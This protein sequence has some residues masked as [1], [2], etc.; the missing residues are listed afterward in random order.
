M[1][2]AILNSEKIIT[3]AKAMGI[4][5]IEKQVTPF[6]FNCVEDTLNEELFYL[7][8]S[9]EID[10]ASEKRKIVYTHD[11][12]TR[13]VVE[14]PLIITVYN[15]HSQVSIGKHFV[16]HSKKRK[17]RAFMHHGLDTPNFVTEL[18]KH[19]E[20]YREPECV[21]VENTVEKEESEPI[22]KSYLPSLSTQNCLVM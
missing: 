18:L 21:V 10:D 12:R 17:S 20:K 6:V 22:K 8:Q 2:A 15:D 7:L 11:G 14:S 19:I 4:I 9:I 16:G 5:V 3:L 13:Y 1:S